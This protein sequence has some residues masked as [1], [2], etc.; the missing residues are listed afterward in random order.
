M[1][2][3]QQLQEAATVPRGEGGEKNGLELFK[4]RSLRKRGPQS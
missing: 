4:F 1:S 3:G 2:Q